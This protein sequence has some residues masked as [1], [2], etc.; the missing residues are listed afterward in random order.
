MELPLEDTVTRQLTMDDLKEGQSIL[1]LCDQAFI[2]AQVDDRPKYVV[3]WA[4]PSTV[5]VVSRQEHLDLL[6]AATK[7]NG[8]K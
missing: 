3:L 6:G 5:K 7:M 2:A 4:E 8:G 1:S